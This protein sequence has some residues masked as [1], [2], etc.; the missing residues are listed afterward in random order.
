MRL[1]DEELAAWG[2]ANRDRL[3]LPFLG[4]L[5]NEELA[6]A[7]G[8]QQAALWA[9]GSK[10]MALREGLSPVGL[11]VL[12]EELRAAALRACTAGDASSSSSSTSSGE[13]EDDDDGPHESLRLQG[14]AAAAAAV[15]AAAPPGYFGAA[16]AAM[17]Q[18]SFAEATAGMGLS[19]EGLALFQQQAA[20]LEAVVGASRARSLTEVI[21]RARVA[22]DPEGRGR[23]GGEQ[24]R[25]LD[26]L[27]SA[28]AAV[29]RVPRA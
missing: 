14:P 3:T 19:P 26:R 21:G 29:S 15:L 28:D 5:A 1:P 22:A 16:A 4:W 12:Q 18:S 27:A 8:E 17:Q 9:L 20:A 7:G 24:R 6:A 23:Q 13:E 25:Q 2:A 10:L 11:E